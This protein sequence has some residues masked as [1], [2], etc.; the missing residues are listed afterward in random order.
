M[1]EQ[2]GLFSWT[3]LVWMRSYLSDIKV[4][5]CIKMKRE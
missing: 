3:W 4:E 5:V 2:C 1:K